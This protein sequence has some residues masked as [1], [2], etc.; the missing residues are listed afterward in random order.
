MQNR[1]AIWVFTILLALA[2]LYQLSFSFFTSSF[3]SDAT[4]YAISEIANLVEGDEGYGMNNDAAIE[5]FEAQYRTDNGNESKFLG[6]TYNE[7]KD[8]E[9]K[10]GLDLE[11]GMS[12]TL[13]V[14]VPDL[15]SNLAANA[16]SETFKSALSLAKQ[17]QL[18]DDGSFIDL[19]E[20]AWEETSPE[21]SLAKVFSGRDNKAMF[22]FESSNDEII[23]ILKD[24]TKAALS[25]TEKILR[26]RIDRFGVTQPTIQK[27]QFTD[28]ILVEL[29]GVKDRERM[30]KLLKSTANLEFWETY[31]NTEPVIGDKTFVQIIVEA[32]DKLAQIISPEL[33][34]EAAE[35]DENLGFEV[36]EG[37]TIYDDVEE[38]EVEEQTDVN[39]KRKSP[40]LSIFTPNIFNSP[41]GQVMGTGPQIGSAL[42]EDTAKVNEYFAMKVV[43]DLLP[44]EDKIKLMWSSKVGPTGRLSLHALKVTTKNGK[45]KLDGSFIVD[46]RQD[47]EQFSK[48]ALVS[49]SMDS[50][51]AKI[52]QRM[53]KEAASQDPKRCIAIALDNAVQSAPVV[54]GEIAG[55]NSQ[56]TMGSQEGVDVVNEAIDLANLLKAGALPAPASI[57]DEQVVGPSL[58]KENIDK[59][60]MAF[61]IA[62]L[63]ILI[64]MFFYYGKAGG[65]ADFALIA[66]MFFLLG[67]LA[68]LHATL[69]LPGIAGIILTIG[70]AVDANVLIFERIKEE[71]RSGAG[72]RAAVSKGY[73]K[74]Y[75]AIID[76]N[77]TTLI[78]AIVLLIFGS[79]PIKGFATTLIIGIATSLFSA[80]FITRLIITGLLER[81]KD[82]SFFNSMTENWM[83]NTD[84]QF[85][86]KRKIFYGVSALII[87]VGLGSLF[88]RQL[89][90]GV[91]FA[92]GRTYDIAF[93]EAV[94]VQS[95]KD[96]L[97]GAFVDE[98]N[99]KL[100]PSVKRLGTSGDKVKITTKYLINDK[101]AD[102]DARVDKALLDG[103]KAVGTVDM[104]AF[105]SKKVD[106]TISDDFQWS[107]MKAISIALLFIFLYI[108]ARFRKAQFG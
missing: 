101:S 35:A 89:D 68:S 55:G 92:G 19:F 63:V 96:A 71:M 39:D 37:D 8:K 43:K 59:A 107:S 22:P 41:N 40:L 75:S 13:E 29:P 60:L 83:A 108:F 94:E 20:E 84:F 106:P 103:L 9:I 5:K 26:T 98:N 85:V 4:E 16:N 58:G 72:V 79:G 52:W 100:P 51:G 54:N 12:V 14:S 64:Y 46:A 104:S 61:G 87:L 78:T 86:K 2:S 6:Y 91:D 62:F 10:K 74:A 69:T 81:G 11:G 42:K 90:L 24:Q 66:N 82:V 17:K 99:N 1:T 57:V 105:G 73:S 15:V 38:D 7:S 32:N 44:A 21:G 76:A 48:Q 67:A 93:T 102:V 53:T 3:E 25:N 27:Q 45:P 95:V 88:T 30:R 80:I 28:R 65:V 33:V 36:I 56:I 70:M 77:L 49:M 50:E 97:D 23:Q 47:F 31:E 18:N 34:E